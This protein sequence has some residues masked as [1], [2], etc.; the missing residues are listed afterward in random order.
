MKVVMSCLC[1]LLVAISPHTMRCSNNHQQQ[2]DR[3]ASGELSATEKKMLDD[4]M[5]R[6]KQEPEATGWIK[7]NLEG[8]RIDEP[9]L[10]DRVVQYLKNKH[11][12]EFERV[13][14]TEGYRMSKEME[15]YI[16]PRSGDPIPFPETRPNSEC[17]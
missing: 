9:A 10:T 12:A 3:P 7:I 16:V 4:F 17:S 11:S 1:L 14:I 6:L 15:L 2:S 5:L 13:T 8:K